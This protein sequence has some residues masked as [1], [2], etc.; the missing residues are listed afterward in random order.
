M[1]NLGL[2]ITF[3]KTSNIVQFISIAVLSSKINDL[4]GFFVSDIFIP[5]CKNHKKHKE[6]FKDKF[7]NISGID[8]KIGNIVTK[9]IEF[10]IAIIVI[11][12]LLK[13]FYDHKIIQNN[14]K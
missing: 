5:I 2:L 4:I 11:C 12:I 8:I 10:V 9:I 1:S 6:E 3:F 7:I 14:S 13:Y